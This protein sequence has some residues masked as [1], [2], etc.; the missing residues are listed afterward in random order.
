MI[1]KMWLIRVKSKLTITRPG[2]DETFA[3]R[4]HAADIRIGGAGSAF[5]N[6][7]LA[8]KFNGE[9]YLSLSLREVA[10][11]SASFTDGVIRQTTGIRSHSYRELNGRLRYEI[12]YGANK[13]PAVETF[14]LDFPAGVTFN[15]QGELTPED[16]TDGVRIPDDAVGSYAVLFHKSDYVLG[17]TNY[18]TGK[19][20]HIYAFYLVNE[21]GERFKVPY[22]IDTVA[23]TLIVDHTAAQSFIDSAVTLLLDPDFG[24]SSVGVNI[25]TNPTAFSY[26][27][28]NAADMYTAGASE[29]VDT[30]SF[31]C[32][33]T[34]GTIATAVGIYDITTVTPVNKLVEGSVTATTTAGWQTTAALATAMAN[35][36]KYGAAFNNM[37]NANLEYHYDNDT[38]PS[39]NYDAGS[40]L[41]TTWVSAG[42][43]GR[44]YSVYA[45]YSAAA[46]VVHDRTLSDSIDVSDSSNKDLLLQRLIRDDVDLSDF[47]IRDLSFAIQIITRLLS[48]SVGLYDSI[49]VDL[50]KIF[51]SILSDQVTAYDSINVDLIKILERTIDDSLILHDD[52]QVELVKIFERI[53]PDSIDL[54]D[55]LVRSLITGAFLRFLVMKIS[56]RNIVMSLSDRHILMNI[57]DH[58][59]TGGIQ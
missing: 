17:Q 57:A 10:I 9:A 7:I 2:S 6:E 40:G 36:T 59:P 33:A 27:G 12:N 20:C 39:N 24:Y 18:E 41:P 38:N 15:Y 28:V 48:D 13:P 35:G 26:V 46:G 3:L 19:L 11:S 55:D 4:Q 56:D 42:A 22:L 1:L 47:L 34:T 25:Q 52:I 31:Y 21:L 44:R 37:G 50:I 16:I 49:S 58:N 43:T 32:R 23:K 30:V 45:T 54:S 5:K 29:Q 8:S 53:L 51:E 14:D